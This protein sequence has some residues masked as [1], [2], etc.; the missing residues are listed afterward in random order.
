MCAPIRDAEFPTLV[1]ICGPGTNIR[2]EHAAPEHTEITA[3]AGHHIGR[4]GGRNKQPY[5]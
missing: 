4:T 3:A 5:Q 2:I 1:A